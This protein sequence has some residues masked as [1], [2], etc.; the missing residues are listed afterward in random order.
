MNLS[1]Q[2]LNRI[3]ELAYRTLPLQHI[4][5]AIEVEELEFIDEVCTPGTVARR[6]YMAGVLQQ[7]I[8]T[9]EFIIK[10]ARN[11]SNPA[12]SELLRFLNESINILK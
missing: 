11:G 8:E 10:S 1:L 2:Q 3:T 6:A 12:Q 4:A 9:R 7:T 5:Y